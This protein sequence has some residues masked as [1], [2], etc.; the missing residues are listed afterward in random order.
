M[1]NKALWLRIL[2]PLTLAILLIPLYVLGALR[3]VEWLAK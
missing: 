3:I 1:T 2:I